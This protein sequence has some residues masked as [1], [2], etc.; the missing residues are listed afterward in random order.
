MPA[1]RPDLADRIDALLP[2]T[3]CT[4]CGYDGCRPYARAIAA[5]EADIDR[6][7]PGGQAGV[8]ALAA[9]LGRAEA[10]PIDTTRG[11]TRP[12]HAARIDGEACIGCTLC[13][14]ACPVDAI[15]GAPRR[16]HAVIAER[17]SGCDLCL[18]ACP[19]DCITMHPQPRP[20]SPVDAT[21]ARG[22][23]EARSARLVRE[24]HQDRE[25]LLAKATAKHAALASE[26]DDPATARKRA[27]IEAAIRRARERLGV[28]DAR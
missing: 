28:A 6:C 20:W 5:D 8:I 14:T 22:R 7:P 25:R 21:L 19:V 3:Q 10:P 1:A 17:C 11:P 9:L 2:Q 26:P 23:H 18:P 13:I 24:R 16:M 15:V 27:V 12:W 4:K